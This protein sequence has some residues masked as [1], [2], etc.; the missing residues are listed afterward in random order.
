MECG[1]SA[2]PGRQTFGCVF[3]NE[4]ESTSCSFDGGPA[5]TCSFPLV[6]GIDRFGTDNHTVEV[7]AVDE[8]GQTLSFP[9]SFALAERESSGVL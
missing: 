8:F 5:E 3:T 6:V 1:I 9:L 7:T 4:L 2:V